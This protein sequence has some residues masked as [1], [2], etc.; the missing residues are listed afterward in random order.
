MARLVLITPSL[1]G[2]TNEYSVNAVVHKFSPNK[3]ILCPTELS[4][5]VRSVGEA[6]VLHVQDMSTLPLDQ[7]NSFVNESP[8]KLLS[9]G[10][11]NLPPIITKELNLH[12]VHIDNSCQLRV[13]P[14]HMT[15]SNYV[16]AKLILPVTRTL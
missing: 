7:I 14:A 3:V 13:I 8:D 1:S 11:V 4:C 15:K 10:V 16:L 9:Q 6:S 5:L 2:I 12:H